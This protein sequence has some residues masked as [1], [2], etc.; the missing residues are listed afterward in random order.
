MIAYRAVGIIKLA[1]LNK[2]NCMFYKHSRTSIN[3]PDCP[4]CSFKETPLNSLSVS[5][6]EDDFSSM[7]YRKDTY[8]VVVGW[9]SN[10]SRA[11]HSIADVKWLMA[12]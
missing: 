11:H 8:D 3:L 6:V 7:H 12:C 4:R 10:K 5:S 2:T 1:C 9:R